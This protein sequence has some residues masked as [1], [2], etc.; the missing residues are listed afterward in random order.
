METLDRTA[1]Y[2]MILHLIVSMILIMM[3]EYANGLGQDC[4]R[5]NKNTTEY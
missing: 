3:R 4:V 2:T 5:L 1:H